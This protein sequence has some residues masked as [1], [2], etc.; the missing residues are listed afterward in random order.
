MLGLYYNEE[1]TYHEIAEVLGVTTSRVC[2]LHGRAISRLRAE[3]ESVSRA[4]D[5]ASEPRR[6]VRAAAPEATP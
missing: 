4:S 1:L 6:N 2:Q 5:G 3:I